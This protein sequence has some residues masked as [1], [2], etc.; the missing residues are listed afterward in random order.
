MR[1]LSAILSV[2]VA[3]FAACQSGDLGTGVNTVE[4]G[5][6][7]QLE[8]V[9][10]AS[11]KVVKDAGLTPVSNRHDAMGGEIVARR[12]NDRE[13]RM[14]LKSLDD[15]HVLV[16]VRVEPGDAALAN[17]LQERLA[18]GLGLGEAKGGL[19]GGHSMEQVC[20]ADLTKCHAAARR[21]FQALKYPITGEEKHQTRSA[22]D[23]RAEGSMPLRIAIESQGA[24]KC[25]VTFLAGTSKTDDTKALVA[26]IKE[27][28]CGALQ[29]LN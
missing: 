21:A 3:S 19:F 25:K 26:R 13:V 12:A 28:F 14:S 20:D 16:S 18:T 4:R 24:D 22:V 7:M 15:K 9:W 1:R 27:E 2:A 8:K 5:Y 6:M 10:S 17:S 23:A 29:A 11:E